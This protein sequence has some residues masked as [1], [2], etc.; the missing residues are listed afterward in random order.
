MR[1]EALDTVVVGG[2][3]ALEVDRCEGGL[4][5]RRRIGAMMAGAGRRDQQHQRRSQGAPHRP[6]QFHS[7]IVHLANRPPSRLSTAVQMDADLLAAPPV[8]S[9]GRVG[10]S[11]AYA[12]NFTHPEGLYTCWARF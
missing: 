6:G 11:V 2:D 5:P 9:S 7:T 12:R 4:G 1:D 8:R 3:H 10:Y